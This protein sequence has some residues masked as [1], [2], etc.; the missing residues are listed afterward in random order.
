L[1]PEQLQGHGN[2]PSADLYSLGAILYE[3]LTGMP[4]FSTTQGYENSIGLQLRQSPV[5]IRRRNP[6]VS[7]SLEHL[8]LKL[9]EKSPQQ[10]PVSA[11]AV[12]KTLSNLAPR[13]RSRPLMGRDRESEQLCQHLAT[14]AQGNSGLIIVHGQRGIGKTQ[15]VLSALGDRVTDQ[16]IDILYGELYAH[17]DQ[18]PYKVFVD[19]LRPTLLDLPAHRLSQHLRDLRD[20]SLSLIGLMPQIR[21]SLS[22]FSPAEGDC[23]R[24]EQAYCRILRLMTD[25]G[26]VVLILD[27]V[28]WIDAASLRLLNRLVREKIP[29]LLIVALYRTEQVGQNHP[30][31]RALQALDESITDQLQIWPLGPIEVHQLAALRNTSVPSDFGLWLFSTTGGNPLHIEHLIHAYVAGPSG[32]HHPPERSPSMTLD[33]AILRCLERLPDRVL[34]TLRQAAVLG[35]TFSYET[36]HEAANLSERQLLAYL[37]VALEE[38]LIVGHPS[39]NRYRFS[40]PVVREVIYTEML[41]GVRKRYH[42]RAAHALE[43]EGV[44][45]I[46]DEKIDALAHHFVHAGDYEKAV[47]YLARAIRRAR[48]L[49]AYE[50]ALDYVN[51]ALMVVEQLSHGATDELEQRQ[52][53]RDD[54][55]AAREDL[56]ELLS[57]WVS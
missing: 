11:S 2:S 10:R 46:A 47:A 43:R 7:R 54:L 6:N 30:L 20:L 17:E 15:L 27:S 32:T 23:D 14:V 52:K 50:I 37:N 40:H 16:P 24:L 25:D 29:G 36:L 34:V 53:Q 57:R 1:A 42:W 48:R 26:P 28:Q 5:P 33:D 38:N 3:I 41:A 51:Q 4:P 35:H 13:F 44:A 9:L 8:V 56:D 49:C 45:G 18:R 12:R 39:E 22:A 55:L 31:Q 21:P 19:A